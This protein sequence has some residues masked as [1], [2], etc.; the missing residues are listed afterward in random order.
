MRRSALLKK[1]VIADTYAIVELLKGNAAYAQLARESRWILTEHAL[2]EVYF[3]AL[4]SEGE[5]YAQ[6]VYERWS[7]HTE[8][9]LAAAVQKGMQFKLQHKNEKPSYADCIGWGTA[10]ALGIP[11]LTGDKAFKGKP[12]VLWV[13]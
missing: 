11:F 8:P 5:T 13:Q 12:G 4:R 7:E 9:L 1:D 10:Q 3:Q 2:V 6:E